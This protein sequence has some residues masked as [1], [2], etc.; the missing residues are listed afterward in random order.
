MLVG[1]LGPCAGPADGQQITRVQPV[2]EVEQK[3]PE[4]IE[5]GSPFPVEIVVR[6]A[7]TAPADDLV[8]TDTLSRGCELVEA[9]PKPECAEET[10]TWRFRRLDPGQHLTLKLLLTARGGEGTVQPRSIVGVTFQGRA[11][12]VCVG[13]L[14][15]PELALSVTVPEAA[16]ARQAVTLQITM[17]NKGLTP[18]RNVTLQTLLGEG[19]THPQGSD[20]ESNV[21]DLAAGESRSVALDVLPTRPGDLQARVSVQAPNAPRARQEV[22]VRAEENPLTLTAQGPQVLR[23]QLTGLYELTVRNG[24]TTA[25]PVTLTVVLPPGITFVHASDNGS[26]DKQTHSIRWDFGELKAA[27]ER[28]VA[29]NGAARAV[30]EQGC[31]A[32]LTSGARTYREAVTTTRTAP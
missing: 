30:G 26:Y 11:S 15:L 3:M 1:V 13:Q 28:G 9:S 6:N 23:Q 2:V 17:T 8:V 22:V 12:S 24:G 20:L 27:E 29:W 21:G 4:S 7:G 16:F 18:V 14:R 10:L 25:R 19:L 32:R 31:K 5:A